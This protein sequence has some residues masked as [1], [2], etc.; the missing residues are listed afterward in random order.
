[1]SN[2]HS[3]SLGGRHYTN[4]ANFLPVLVG[5]NQQLPCWHTCSKKGWFICI[6]VHLLLM[7]GGLKIAAQVVYKEQGFLGLV[8][9]F[10][11]PAHTATLPQPASHSIF[12]ASSPQLAPACRQTLRFLCFSFIR[13][14]HWGSSAALLSP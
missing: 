3:F 8:R 12:S 7:G 14:I 9:H 13:I 4:I 1:M 5:A 6:C 10:S 11:A 2:T